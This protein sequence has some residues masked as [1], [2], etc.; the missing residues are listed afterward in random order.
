MMLL[1]VKKRMSGQGDT[2][3]GVILCSHL[4]T[5]HAHLSDER[6]CSKTLFSYRLYLEDG[7]QF[8]LSFSCLEAG[9]RETRAASQG[10]FVLDINRPELKF[11]KS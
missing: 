6:A 1:P 9:K 10:Y 2:T 5:V 4:I 11:R 3:W 8:H 7:G